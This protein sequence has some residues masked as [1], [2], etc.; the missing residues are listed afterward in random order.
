M[1]SKPLLNELKTILS[2]DCGKDLSDLEVSQIANGLADYFDL[3]AEIAHR[4]KKG[5]KNPDLL[6]GKEQI[7]TLNLIVRGR[8]RSAS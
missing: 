3:L 2:E 1:L 4:I 6:P 7:R 8:T 5:V